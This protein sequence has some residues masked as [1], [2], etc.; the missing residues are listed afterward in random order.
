MKT[1]YQIAVKGPTARV[2]SRKAGSRPNTGGIPISVLPVALFSL[3][4]NSMK[5]KAMIPP[6]YPQAEPAPETLPISSSPVRSGIRELVKIVANSI[7]IRP[8]PNQTIAM[9]RL[10]STGLR[11]HSIQ[12]PIT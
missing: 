12:L 9:N 1:T 5:I 7:P 3:K 10:G 8:R 2:P 11:Y 4:N 6:K